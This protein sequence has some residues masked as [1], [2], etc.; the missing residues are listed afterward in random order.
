M[1]Q[2]DATAPVSLTRAR[3]AKARPREIVLAH[4]DGSETR[5][6]LEWSDDLRLA[7]VPFGELVPRLLA[8]RLAID[9][10]PVNRRS[11]EEARTQDVLNTI[12]VIDSELAEQQAP[13]APATN[14]ILSLPVTIGGIDHL[15]TLIA[16]G[17]ALADCQGDERLLAAVLCNLGLAIDGAVLRDWQLSQLST[18]TVRHLAESVGLAIE[19]QGHGG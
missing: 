19:R 4:S 3:R 8:A 14:E 10:K 7:D 12:A 2:P 18:G 5:Y 9:G 17:T 16:P 11:L 13:A 1:E 6:G 15:V